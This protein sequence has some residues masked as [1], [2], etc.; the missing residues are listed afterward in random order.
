ML[1]QTVYNVDVGIL[2]IICSLNH[3]HQAE[4]FADY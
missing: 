1:V 3:W 4:L 2:A